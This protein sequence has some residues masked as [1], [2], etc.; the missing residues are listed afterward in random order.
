MRPAVHLPAGHVRTQEGARPT[1]AQAPSQPPLWWRLWLHIDEPRAVAVVHALTYTILCAGCDDGL[2]Y[3]PT[4]IADETGSVAICIV[5]GGML[6]IR[7]AFG[8]IVALPGRS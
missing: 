6:A 8:T 2:L 3:P 4:S 7:G 5:A 1:T